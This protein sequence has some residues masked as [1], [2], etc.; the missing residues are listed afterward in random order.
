MNQEP[1]IQVVRQLHQAGRGK[2]EISRLLKISRNTVR[3]LLRQDGQLPI[4]KRDEELTTL[5]EPLITTCRG[6]LV[7]IKEVLEQQ[8]QRK[9]AYSTLTYLVRKHQLKEI[10][11]RVG[12]YCFAPGEEMQHDTS[13]HTIY[14]GDKKVK[15]Q[16]AALVLGFS[17]KIFMQYYPN[18][19]RFEAKAFLQQA[20]QF[21]QGSCKR[22]IIDNTSVVLAAGAGSNAIIAPEMLMFCRFFGFEFVAHAVNNP[23]RKGKI[24]KPFAYAENN[25]LA[26]RS[27]TDWQDL[28]HQAEQWCIAVNQKHKR[29]LGMTPEA[30]Y[31]QEKPTLLALPEVMPPIYKCL[32]RTVDTQ[33]YISVDTNRYSVPERYIGDLLEVYQYLDRIEIYYQHRLI[34]QHPR[35]IER[36]N[37]RSSIKGHHINLYSL[38][39]RL[40]CS[41]A[42][43]QLTG[44]NSTLD[45]YILMLK[46]QVRGRGE[47]AFRELLM[48]KRNYPFEAFIKAV[49]LAKQY[50]LFDL[51]RLEKMII[52]E[53]T[54]NFFN[55]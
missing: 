11:Q 20:L 49:T 7:R 3:K 18:F 21:M 43:Q 35:I 14:F 19:T 48:F 26:G 9:V 55:I 39:R 41:E 30:A 38:E 13:P 54:D 36:R 24:E 1:L 17:R 25:F 15:G 4:K 12:E 6:N 27:F 53:I 44:I 45:A 29:I 2:R 33:G 5:I 23:N 28:N 32:Q 47:L 10:P 22:C 8:H 37:Q 16:C 50:S 40:A 34:T 46:S 31:V 42:E 52:R 51:K